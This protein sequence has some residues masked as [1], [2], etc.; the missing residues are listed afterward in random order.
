MNQLDLGNIHDTVSK[1]AFYVKSKT[2][3][4]PLS[5]LITNFELLLNSF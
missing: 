5:L 3:G 2:L 1:F 4:M